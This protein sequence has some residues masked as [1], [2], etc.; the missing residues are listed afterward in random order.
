MIVER[1]VVF[2]QAT[3]HVSHGDYSRCRRLESKKAGVGQ[4]M[5]ALLFRIEGGSRKRLLDK[6]PHRQHALVAL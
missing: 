1:R 2:N 5:R 3:S 6:E 4:P